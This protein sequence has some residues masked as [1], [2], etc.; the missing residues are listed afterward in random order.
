MMSFIANLVCNTV[1]FIG[2]KTIWKY[3]KNN[4]RI[5][6]R[7]YKKILNINQDEELAEKISK[8]ELKKI[9][10]ARRI[11]FWQKISNLFN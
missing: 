5:V 8:L 9:V 11:L 4:K 10:Q 2:R 1:D 6:N 3:N 7:R